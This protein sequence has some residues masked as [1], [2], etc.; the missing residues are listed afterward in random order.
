MENIVMN[1]LYN[2]KND[3]ITCRVTYGDKQILKQIADSKN[4]A[5]SKYII[6]AAKK[7]NMPAEYYEKKYLWRWSIITSVSNEL[8]CICEKYHAQ[9]PEELLEAV[10]RL[11]REVSKGWQF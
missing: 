8:D 4:M 6:E 5:L 11:R 7:G 1:N 3:K 10:E 9:L 2:N